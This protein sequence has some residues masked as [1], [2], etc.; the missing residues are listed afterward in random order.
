MI[1][2]LFRKLIISTG[3]LFAWLVIWALASKWIGQ[4]LLL[5]SPMDTLRALLQLFQKAEFWGSTGLSLLRI[6][7]GFAIGVAIGFILAALT[8]RVNFIKHFIAPFLSSVKATPVVSFILLAYVWLSPGSVPVFATFLIVLPIAYA[9]LSTGFQMLDPL[10][11][12]MGKG[13]RLSKRRLINAIY[14]PMISP[15]VRAAIASGMGMAWKAGIAAEVIATPKKS[16]G[17][18]LY[19]AKVYLDTP[20][21][22]ASTIVVIML[23]ILLEKIVLRLLYPRKGEKR[24]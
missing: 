23:S 10:L 21:L 18:W 3:A 22:F 5:P 15:Y 12:E 14:W 20:G 13:F 19:Q 24:I 4:T 8:H 16:L 2:I 11:L 17:S 7:S 9:N 1:S 6:L